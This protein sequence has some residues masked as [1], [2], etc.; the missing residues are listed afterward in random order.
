MSLSSIPN[1]P[2]FNVSTGIRR[3]ETSSPGSD[4]WEYGYHCFVYRGV[5]YPDDSPFIPAWILAEFEAS[6]GQY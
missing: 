2:D 6:I 4:E 3:I 5:F 1:S